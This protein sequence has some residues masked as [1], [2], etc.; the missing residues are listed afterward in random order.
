MYGAEKMY[1]TRMNTPNLWYV[2]MRK[3]YSTKFLAHYLFEIFFI[4]EG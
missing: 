1:K 4:V 3:E 2:W